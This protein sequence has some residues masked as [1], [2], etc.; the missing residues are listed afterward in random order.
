MNWHENKFNFV[1]GMFDISQ[2][3]MV[4][5]P[6]DFGHLEGFQFELEDLNLPKAK[7]TKY[8]FHKCDRKLDFPM[9][10][11]DEF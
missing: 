8:G 10:I 7:I 5:I 6:E 9:A 1:F 4:D 3:K 11:E 2:A